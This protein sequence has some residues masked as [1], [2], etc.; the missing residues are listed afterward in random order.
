MALDLG[1]WDG[2]LVWVEEIAKEQN[3]DTVYYLQGH[4]ESQFDETQAQRREKT[5]ICIPVTC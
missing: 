5:S 3:Q 1:R 2:S 4:E